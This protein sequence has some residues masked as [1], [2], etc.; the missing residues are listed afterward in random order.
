VEA[1]C[2]QRA[3]PSAP[4]LRVQELSVHRMWS[5]L[6]PHEPDRFAL[7]H[8]AIEPVV[9]REP[10]LAR[11]RGIVLQRPCPQVV[12]SYQE[13]CFVVGTGDSLP[14]ATMLPHVAACA[15]AWLRFVGSNPHR[16]QKA[17]FNPR[18][19]ACA[20]VHLDLVP[21]SNGTRSLKFSK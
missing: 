6:Q 4:P 10:T 19:N 5:L 20:R 15:M 12:G 11:Q 9:A 13:P 18:R 1:P 17:P 21:W 3:E 14:R 16:S 7:A 8:P 2:G